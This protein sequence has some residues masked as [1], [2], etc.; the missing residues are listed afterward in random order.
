MLEG[1]ASLWLP[2]TPFK[3][4]VW[5]APRPESE[6]RRQAVV[7]SLD[8]F[9]ERRRNPSPLVSVGDFASGLTLVDSPAL[10]LLVERCK[11]EFQTK[12]VLL[13]VVDGDRTRHL[14]SVG[15]PAGVVD[16]QR[17]STFCGH[18]ILS[19]DG[20]TVLDRQND[21]RFRCNTYLTGLQAEFYAGPSQFTFSR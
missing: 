8:L 10:Q 21:W 15:A 11:E 19:K 16:Q 1:I 20:M 7:D 12:M 14:A 17:D 5:E 4:G 13:K 3:E 2:C 6:A 9:S 18:T